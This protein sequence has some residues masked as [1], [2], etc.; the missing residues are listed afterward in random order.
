MQWTYNRGHLHIPIHKVLSLIGDRRGN[1]LARSLLVPVLVPGGD[2]V[3]GGGL[4]DSVKLVQLRLDDVGPVIFV[5]NLGTILAEK[6]NLMGLED[7]TRH[8]SSAVVL[9][10]QGEITGEREC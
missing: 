9:L 8:P 6:K 10:G 1:D 7:S 3:V 5:H 2:D 4:I